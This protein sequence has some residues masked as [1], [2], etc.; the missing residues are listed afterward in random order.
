MK[1]PLA[2]ATA[3]VAR[4]L[5]EI[6]PVTA[7]R[8]STELGLTGTAVRRQLDTLVEAGF[9]EANDRAPF[10]P[11]KPQGRGR[12]ARVYTLTDAGRDAFDQAYDALAIAALRHM[13]DTG[14]DAAVMEFARRRAGDMESRYSAAVGTGGSTEA[15]VE[16][17]AA[18]LRGDGFVPG[19]Q[20]AG[21]A[22]VQVCQHHCPI[23]HVAQEFPQ[24][25]EAETEA[26]GRLV[27]THVTRLATLS[28]GDGVCTTHIPINDVSAHRSPERTPA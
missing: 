10:G 4:V 19:V 6:G 27:G 21:A 2:G 7:S 1:S 8:L 18:A 5:Q 22:G 15:R 3:R 9:A 28:H 11:T 26:F 16:L 25:C 20:S 12:P 14:G 17:L 13:A 23:A 24:I